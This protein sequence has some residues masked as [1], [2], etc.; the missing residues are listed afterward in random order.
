MCIS[1]LERGAIIIA[2]GILYIPK[3]LAGKIIYYPRISD[4]KKIRPEDLK[5]KEKTEIVN[6]N[7]VS[8]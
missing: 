8:Y 6:L 3:S 1:Q 4:I 7:F 2:S 5:K